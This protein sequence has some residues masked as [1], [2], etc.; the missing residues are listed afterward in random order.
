MK[1]GV[2]RSVCQAHGQCALADPQLFTI[3]DEGYSTIGAS[4][5]VPRGRESS[6]QLGVDACPVR[7]LRIV[8]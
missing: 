8:A 3:D 7:A 4:K 1:V 2:D 5:D 6:A